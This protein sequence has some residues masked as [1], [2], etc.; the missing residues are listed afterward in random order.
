M[1]EDEVF[2]PNEKNVAFV[3]LDSLP[4]FELKLVDK[5]INTDE[6]KLLLK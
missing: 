1:I 6:E 4:S 2:N 5:S 3:T